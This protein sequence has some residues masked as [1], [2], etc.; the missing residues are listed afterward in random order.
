MQSSMDG[1][2]SGMLDAMHALAGG[3]R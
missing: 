1:A 3:A 2:V